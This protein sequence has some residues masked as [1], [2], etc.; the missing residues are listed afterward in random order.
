MGVAKRSCW[1][2]EDGILPKSRVSPRC[3]GSRS[4]DRMRG[5]DG[6]TRPEQGQ[7]HTLGAWLSQTKSLAPVGFPRTSLC[8][9]RL[10]RGM[11]QKPFPK[12]S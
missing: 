5:T 9:H 7:L 2:R 12:A 8:A 1:D 10:S 6:D 11:I 4:R 3:P